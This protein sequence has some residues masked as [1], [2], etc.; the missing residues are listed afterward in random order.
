MKKSKDKKNG[1]SHFSAA[2]CLLSYQARIVFDSDQVVYFVFA[3]LFGYEKT[4]IIILIAPIK[5][6]LHK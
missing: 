2:H 4:K 3:G 1:I 6:F 5:V